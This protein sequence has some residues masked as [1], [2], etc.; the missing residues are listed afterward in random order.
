MHERV[1]EDKQRIVPPVVPL[2]GDIDKRFAA[3][4]RVE[5]VEAAQR[6]SQRSV[7]HGSAL[8]LVE[9]RAADRLHVFEVALEARYRERSLQAPA[10]PAQKAHAALL[11][12]H[13]A[14]KRFDV[15]E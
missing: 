15:R 4:V 10:V 12:R 3:L 6:E 7:M 1:V 11:A 13:L 8:A 14:C 2:A 5:I 9:Y